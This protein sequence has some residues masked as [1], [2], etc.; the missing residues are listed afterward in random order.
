[1]FHLILKKEALVMT[2]CCANLKVPSSVRPCGKTSLPR[3]A[4]PAL[5]NV[6]LPDRVRPSDEWLH[7]C[8]MRSTRSQCS[9]QNY[10]R[11]AEFLSRT[12]V[13]AAHW[14]DVIHKVTIKIGVIQFLN[15]VKKSTIQ[16]TNFHKRT[17]AAKDSHNLE[18]VLCITWKQTKINE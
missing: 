16:F 7:W 6:Q 10:E 5:L 8:W 12:R 14:D 9:N 1:M 11:T 3:L 2:Y 17:E 13:A 18:F 4:N 15:A